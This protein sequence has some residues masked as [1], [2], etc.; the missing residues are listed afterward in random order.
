MRVRRLRQ[1]DSALAAG[2]Q[3]TCSLSRAGDV[4]CWGTNSWG[5][6]GVTHAATDTPLPIE[7]IGTPVARIAAGKAHA[8]AIT[9][10]SEVWCWGGN[11]AG[12]LGVPTVPTNT[13]SPRP[14]KISGL[15]AVEIA[16]G[17]DHTC[18]VTTAHTLEMLGQERPRSAR[19]CVGHEQPRSGG[20][21]GARRRQRNCCRIHALLRVIRGDVYC[22]G[23]NELG[24]LGDGIIDDQSTPVGARGVGPSVTSIAAGDAFTCAVTADGPICW[25]ANASGQ[26]GLGR[27]TTGPNKPVFVGGLY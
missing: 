12:K 14:V 23:G 9:T 6:L 17:T 3:S 19:H 10:T 7:P 8:C 16:A 13:N 4:H 11:Y 1:W 25:G 22:W 5:N 20:N 27:M 26:L 2:L 18:V 24:Q 15:L 21:R